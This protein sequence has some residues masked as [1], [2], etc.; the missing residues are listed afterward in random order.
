MQ[1]NIISYLKSIKILLK[2]HLK[3]TVGLI[4]KTVNYF[5]LEQKFELR[6]I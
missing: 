4:I 6:R 5:S 2:W 3:S 1:Q